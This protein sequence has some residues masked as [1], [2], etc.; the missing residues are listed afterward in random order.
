MLTFDREVGRFRDSDGNLVPVA[1]VMTTI[2]TVITDL[3][4][5]IGGLTLRLTDGS[6]TNDQWLG[7]M[8]TLLDSGHI[9]VGTIAAGGRDQMTP[10]LWAVIAASIAAEYR[11]LLRFNQQ[12]LRGQVP[13]T[14]MVSRAR[15]YP[16][17]IRRTFTE[18]VEVLKPRLYK[19]VYVKR[20]RTASESC[21]GCITWANK[22]WL[23]YAQM[24]KI[25]SLQCKYFCKCYLVFREG[26]P[27]AE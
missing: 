10:A 19:D 20:V 22:G 13:A 12:Y 3:E 5:Q 4:R 21:P 18:I 1:V 23:P 8:R 6:I 27:P 9:L 16:S 14:R 26:P 2:E 7:G 25:G 17:G 15:L 11:Y 24:A